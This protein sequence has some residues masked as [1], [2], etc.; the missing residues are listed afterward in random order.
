MMGVPTYARY[1]N[2]NTARGMHRG[3][4][5]GTRQAITLSVRLG[6]GYVGAR[7]CNHTHYWVALLVERY[8]SNTASFV[9]CVVCRVKDHHNSLHYES[10]SSQYNKSCVRQV[11]LDKWLP[12][13]LVIPVSVN[14]H[15]FYLSLGHAT[16]QQ[17]LQSGPRF[18]VLKAYVP[19][20][21]L[22]RR[23][24]FFFTDS[25]I[26]ITIIFISLLLITITLISLLL[27]TINTTSN[28]Q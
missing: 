26:I 7:P 14:K 4:H 25:G 9:L 1:I 10:L 5:R 18:G 8:V 21:L 17:K 24:V 15:S 23:Y 22:I 16:Q 6:E 28:E 13:P 27:I 11:V 20:C 19:T 2:V 3:M 12:L